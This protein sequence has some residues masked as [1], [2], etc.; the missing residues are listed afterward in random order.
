MKRFINITFIII[1]LA[2]I[3]LS[4]DD[5]GITDIPIPDENV[6]Y[7]EH[8]QPMFNVHCNTT[9]CH[10][11]ADRAAGLSLQSYGEFR[12]EPFLII[13]GAP[14]ESILYL[15]VSGKYVTLMPPPFGNTLP[16]SDNQINGIRTWIE[17]GA[18]AD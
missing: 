13:A 9:D 2:I 10:N 6:S 17:E 8:I 4:C 12:S 5:T 16:L 11:S 15:V 1:F 18:E 3:I 7:Q 14:E